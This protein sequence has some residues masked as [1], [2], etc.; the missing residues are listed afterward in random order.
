MRLFFLG[1][2]A[3]QKTVGIPWP[4]GASKSHKKTGEIP[5]IEKACRIVVKLIEMVGAT[6]LER[7]T[8][9]SRTLRATNCAT[10]R[11]PCIISSFS[12]LGEVDGLK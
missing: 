12:L 5:V 2:V 9:A 6:R 1:G 4:E 8:S 11:L 3:P 7:A 10:P